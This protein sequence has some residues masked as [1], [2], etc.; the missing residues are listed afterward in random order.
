[1]PILE[2]LSKHKNIPVSLI[3]KGAS[4]LGVELANILIEQGSFVI[5]IDEYTQKKRKLVSSLLNKEKFNFVDVSGTESLVES[6]ER[7]DYIF[8][9]NHEAFDPNEK[10]STS[11]FLEESN[12]LDKL[13]E[14]GVDKSSKFLLTSSIK[15]HRDLQDK[16]DVLSDFDL[17]EEN[18]SYTVLEVQR[19]TENLTWEYYKR[20]GLDARIIRVG[21]IMGKGTDL[22]RDTLLVKYIKDSISGKKIE[23][24]GDGLEHLYFIHVLD[25]AYGLIKALFTEKTSG[26]IY[27]LVIPRDITV[28]NLAYKILDL[29]PR[30]DGIKFLDKKS[31]GEVN[32]YKPDK[33]LKTIGWKPKISFERALANT[34]DYAYKVY[35]K[36]KSKIKKDK[37]DK[38]KDI[39]DSKSKKRKSI[40]DLLI[41]FFFEVKEEKEPSSV[42]D[43][44]RYNSYNKNVLS[45]AEASKEK[46]R[47]NLSDRK[48]QKIPKRSKLR[49]VS[50]KII[51][52]IGNIK[53]SVKSMT[54]LKFSLY[55]FIVIVFLLLYLFF[56]VPFSRIIY[57]GGVASIRVKSANKSLQEKNCSDASY[58]LNRTWKSLDSVYENIGK[59]SYLDV[60][61]IGDYID[62]FQNKIIKAK[63]TVKGADII[64]SSFLPIE[65]YLNSYKSNISVDSNGNL[66]IS[67]NNTYD[68]D[69]LINLEDDLNRGETLIDNSLNIFDDSDFEMQ[70]VGSYLKEFYDN[71]ESI[72]LNLESFEVDSVIIPDILA[73]EN[74]E[75]Y[76]FLLLNENK[77][78]T[79]GGEIVAASVFTVNKGK[80]VDIEVFDVNG[81]DINLSDEQNKFV[82]DDLK[83]LYPEDGLKF[84]DLTLMNDDEIFTELIESVLTEG[85]DEKVEHV[86]TMNFSSLKDMFSFTGGI[87]VTDVGIINSDNFD[88]KLSEGEI[89]FK[90]VLSKALSRIFDFKSGE[91]SLFKNLV[92][93]NLTTKDI[94]IYT[95]DS[96]FK[97]YFIYNDA[98]IDKVDSNYG[99]FD[100]SIISESESMPRVTVDTKININNSDTNG[101]YQLTFENESEG[102]FKGIIVLDFENSTIDD[103]QTHSSKISLSSSYSSRVFFTADLDPDDEDYLVIKESLSDVV[104]SKNEGYNYTLIFKK[105]LGL[106]YD[107]E[108]VIDYGDEL[109]LNEA[110][111]DSV[112]IDTTVKLLNVSDRDYLFNY[113]FSPVD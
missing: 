109:I 40:K 93:S 83:M 100:M 12:T 91:V 62:S 80:V 108:V 15:L 95:N 94:N 44:V 59:L 71:I 16:S 54:P 23:V 29:E 22:N 60:F 110:P 66:E 98:I 2:R 27:S 68:L 26:N 65:E 43:N 89:S 85:L 84:K 81:I 13:L 37:K 56:V 32:I 57:Y 82:R 35:G 72:K 103:I 20:G 87:E 111:S 107:Y 42:L 102:N 11:E 28:L 33:N 51:D 25:A 78:N 77:M 4:N 73:V 112:I 39:K 64:V 10:I 47:V 6:I 41:N 49:V 8:Y 101:E 61:G 50:W 58:D 38:P 19:Y 106:S 69:S 79:K 90:E 14:L 86:V 88:E 74:P 53:D 104:I 113:N 1:M 3:F 99:L 36:R 75:T 45:D 70:F 67:D 46:S 52:F 55:I 24:A 17:D 76:G 48:E 97:R 30:A 31:K 96:N 92:I 34:I 9:L 18:L 21:E 105:A 63:N 7:L 5:L